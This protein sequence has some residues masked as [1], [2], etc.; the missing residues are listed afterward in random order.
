MK[1]EE[2]NTRA[3]KIKL[4]N[5]LRTG[6]TN[7]NEVFP[8]LPEYWV[9]KKG[10]YSRGD[11]ELNEDEFKALKKRKG[12]NWLF[13]VWKLNDPKDIGSKVIETFG[14]C[15]N[16][17]WPKYAPPPLDE[18]QLDKICLA[19]NQSETNAK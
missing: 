8:I 19:L 9:Y 6:K 7:V 3:E 17:E 13:T 11:Q 1:K 5:D 4:L 12:K 2:V 15:E 14:N 16:Y 18:K 10:I